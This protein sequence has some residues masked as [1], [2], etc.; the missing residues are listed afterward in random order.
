VTARVVWGAIVVLVCATRFSH[1]QLLWIEEAY[2]AAA[3]AEVLRGHVLYRDIWFDKPPLYALIYVL[4]NALPGWPLRVAGA[5]YVLLSC[6]VL[7]RFAREMWGPLEST[8]GAAFLALYLTFG[9]PSAVMALAPDLLMMPVHIAALY[10]AWRGQPVASGVL[11]SV[12]LLFNAKGVFV[13]AV[14]VL[15]QLPFA[16]K[17]LAGFAAPQT[18]L[19]VWLLA[20]G[21]LSGYWQQVWVWGAGYS[22]DTLFANPWKEGLLR[23]LNWTGFHAPIV[24]G[25][26]IYARKEAT[27]KMAA[28][29]VLSVCAVIAGF[30]FYPRYFFQLLP[31]VCLA[32][33]RGF[34]VASRTWRTILLL[35]LLV[36][37]IRFAPRYARLAAE[38]MQGT[39]HLWADVAMMQ[40][41]MRAGERLR[42]LATPGDTLL[43]WGYRPDVFVYSRLPAATRF[44]D[45]QPLTG[46]I[47]DRHLTSSD[48]TFP[49]LARNNRESLTRTSPVFIVDGLGP[50]NPQLA[51]TNYPELSMWLSRYREVG[52]TPMC[53]IYK[54][55]SPNGSALG[56]K[57]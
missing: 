29:A 32:A 54:L 6:A 38:Q 17:F 7:Y 43:V 37:T 41:S 5:A 53:R 50:L 23:F 9:I 45:S 21:A 48:A 47:A 16:A 33:S 15:W 30:R 27:R 3:A 26:V 40:D 28:W 10:F 34:A 4:W 42:A 20:S 14:C 1:V 52:H 12:C 2:P 56:Q 18:A 22:A 31:V 44:L 24:I 19:I 46:V 11:S 55:R 8:I 13:A 39:E 57:R 36:P 35:L 25:A 51:I 49:E